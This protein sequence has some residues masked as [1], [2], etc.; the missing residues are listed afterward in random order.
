MNSDSV[1]HGL[2]CM[3]FCTCRVTGLGKAYHSND[4]T[5]WTHS[6]AD[7]VRSSVVYLYTRREGRMQTGPTLEHPMH[8]AKSLVCMGRSILAF[9]QQVLVLCCEVLMSPAGYTT[10]HHNPGRVCA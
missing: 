7:S 3:W 5:C 8:W 9:R 2:M 10:T 4:C 6:Y 1:V